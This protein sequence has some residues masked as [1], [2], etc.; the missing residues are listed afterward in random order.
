MKQYT[1]NYYE[2]GS[3][4]YSLNQK[5]VSYIQNYTPNERSDFINRWE[6]ILKEYIYFDSPKC[7]FT[8]FEKMIIMDITDKLEELKERI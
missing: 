1:T 3:G 5:S 2:G 7:Y 4:R 8:D 6:Y